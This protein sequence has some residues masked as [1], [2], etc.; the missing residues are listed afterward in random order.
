[1]KFNM[2]CISNALMHLMHLVHL[3]MPVCAISLS[4]FSDIIHVKANMPFVW[5]SHSESCEEEE[6]TQM[7]VEKGEK[8]E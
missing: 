6:E 4:A 3:P 1:M 5:C 2:Q 8:K 7:D